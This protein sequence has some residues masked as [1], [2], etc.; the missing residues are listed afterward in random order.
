MKVG[1]CYFFGII[2]P[3]FPMIFFIWYKHVIYA[4]TEYASHIDSLFANCS[5]NPPT[6]NSSFAVVIPFPKKQIHNVMALLY[7]W[8]LPEFSPLFDDDIKLKRRTRL[9][10]YSVFNDTLMS[11]AINSFISDNKKVSKMLKN[12]FNSVEILPRGIEPRFDLHKKDYLQGQWIASGDTEMFYPMM[13]KIAPSLN[14]NFVLYHE[15]DAFPLRKGWLSKIRSYAF[16]EDSDF[17]FL[18]SQQRQKKAISGRIHGH[19]NGNSVIRVD[20]QCARAFLKRVYKEYRYLPYDTSI[21]RYLVNSKNLREAQHLI[22]R[23]RYT[24]LIGNFAHTEVKREDLMKRFPEMYIVHGKGYFKEINH[25]LKE[26]NFRTGFVD[27]E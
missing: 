1:W 13:T 12:T 11:T 21:M 9:I 2:I 23:M 18:G 14:I 16:S 10:L 27:V 15:P 8:S 4:Y 20:N 17:W 24:D 26:A 5:T 7:I 22:R 25:L 6:S 3:L 19:M